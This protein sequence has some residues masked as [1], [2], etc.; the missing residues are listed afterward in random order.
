M[1]CK[2]KMI[3]TVVVLCEP[4]LLPV[5]SEQIPKVKGARTRASLEA[6]PAEQVRH[7]LSLEERP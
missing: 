4:P 1:T 5:Y 6:Y 7:D 2:F 3:Y